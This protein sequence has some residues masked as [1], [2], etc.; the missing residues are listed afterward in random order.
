MI[1]IDTIHHI[2]FSSLNEVPVL[3]CV[4]KCK[5]IFWKDDIQKEIGKCPQCDCEITTAIQGVHFNILSKA[6]RNLKLSD[7]KMYA[8]IKHS[9][10]KTFQSYLAMGAQFPHLSHVKP[11]FTQYAIS[12]WMPIGLKTETTIKYD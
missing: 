10:K 2:T 11:E 5:K 7:I 3:A 1:I 6:N 12:E 9:D 4:G 8:S